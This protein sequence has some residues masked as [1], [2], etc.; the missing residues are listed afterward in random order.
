VILRKPNAHES[1]DLQLLP[2]REP[3]AALLSN[4]TDLADHLAR[5]NWREFYAIEF[6]D[7]KRADGFYRKLR[8]AYFDDEVIVNVAAINRF[9][10][11]SGWRAKP[12][13]ID[14]YRANP[15]SI[16][17]CNSIVKDPERELG[18]EVMVVLKAIRDRIPLDIF[19]VDF[20]VDREGG[21]VFFEASAAMI[22]HGNNQR[23]PIDVRLPEEQFERLD[24]AFRTM[25]RRR[26]AGIEGGRRP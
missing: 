20:E 17:E 19:G 26:V 3:G 21:V 15:R 12:A 11:V 16:E 9:W 1:S 23:A 7:L 8:A 10:M 22:M 4:R 13:G 18:A 5:W 24:D 14:F 6:V 25:I 2:D